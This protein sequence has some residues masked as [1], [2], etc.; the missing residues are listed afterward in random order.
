[1][2]SGMEAVSL[3]GASWTQN[4]KIWCLKCFMWYK[5]LQSQCRSGCY[6]GKPEMCLQG[7]ERKKRT[8]LL[9]SLPLYI[10]TCTVT[11]LCMQSFSS[12]IA[13]NTCIRHAFAD[14]MME[15]TLVG[16]MIFSVRSGEWRCM[17]SLSSISLCV[18]RDLHCLEFLTV[19]D[20]IL[21]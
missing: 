12:L 4:Q 17:C 2:L 21:L 6:S 18:T 14:G 20:S 5:V 1:M 19:R 10:C 3:V 13:F 16:A 8:Y 7:A 9:L 15:D 11:C